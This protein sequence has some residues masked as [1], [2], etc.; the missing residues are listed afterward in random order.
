MKKKSRNIT[1]GLS[2]STIN[3]ATLIVCVDIFHILSKHMK[4][5]VWNHAQTTP[6]PTITISQS[7]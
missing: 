6:T 7:Q 3:Q 5:F 2:E 1:T 4:S